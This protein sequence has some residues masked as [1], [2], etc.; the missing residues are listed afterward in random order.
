MVAKLVVQLNHVRVPAALLPIRIKFKQGRTL[1]N[2]WCD[3]HVLV[4][5][6]AVQLDCARARVLLIKVTKF[7]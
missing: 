5:L 4:V 2:V 1:G 7:G 3:Q 6:L